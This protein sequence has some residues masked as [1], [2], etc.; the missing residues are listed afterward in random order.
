MLAAL[1]GLAPLGIDT[2]LPALPLMARALHTSDGLVQATLGSFMLAFAAGQLV[3][4]PLAD[5]Y[6]RRPIAIA[7]MAVYTL[8]GIFCALAFDA[9]LLVVARFFQGF[10]ACAGTVIARAVIRD[11]FTE[12]T[13]SARMQAYIGAI[14]GFIP[15][16]APLLGAAILPLGWRAIYVT[17]VI[18][19]ALLLAVTSLLLPET[20]KSQER[21][22]GNGFLGI[23]RSS[24]RFLAM[25]RAVSLCALLACSFAG[26]FA[27]ISASPFVLVRELGLSSAAFGVA[28]ALSAASIFGGA[29][30]A[31]AFADRFGSERL[32]RL[33]SGAAAIAGCGAFAF[34]IAL[35][36]AP[37]APLFVAVMALYAVA[38]GVLVPNAF[39]A[40]M[41]HAGAM[42]G[43][44]AGVLGA[45][46]MLG[47]AIGSTINGALPFAPHVNVGLSVASAG[48]ATV[49]CYA[50][51][52]RARYAP[53]AITP[54]A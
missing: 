15:M 21:A 31:G 26:L 16:L 20:L 17:L 54:P 6:G 5:R 10:G 38:F 25:P 33:G 37:P 35:P 34:N 30:F 48:V 13:E 1:G 11:V 32:L 51:S 40:G 18:A 50:L 2:S 49:L 4:G 29:W 43:V 42:A 39:A 47:G 52:T 19:G 22:A 9:R 41:E 14:S 45:A 28:F 12:R 46:Q 44:A 7:G 23:A 24:V 27:F 8:S 53:R 36:H 3:V